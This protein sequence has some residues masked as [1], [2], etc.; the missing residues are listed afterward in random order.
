MLGHEA[1]A[2]PA[3]AATIQPSRTP[4]LKVVSL[5]KHFGGVVA[6]DNVTL[7]ANPGE[8]TA[9]IGENGAGKSTLIKCVSGVYAPDSGEILLGGERIRLSSPLDARV[10][11]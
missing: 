4:G 11:G 6:L 8:V 2:F 3:G 9:L 5:T 7:W 1:P 10:A